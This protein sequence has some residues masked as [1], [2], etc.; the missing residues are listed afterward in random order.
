MFSS[1]ICGTMPQSAPRRKSEP[2]RPAGNH[3]ERSARCRF[4]SKTSRMHTT[5]T[6]DDEFGHFLP[7]N[8]GNTAR[9]ASRPEKPDNNATAVVDDEFGHFLPATSGT[10]RE[11][12]HDQQKPG[13]RKHCHNQRR[14]RPLP[15]S[16]RPDSTRCIKTSDTSR[17]QATAVVDDERGH[18]RKRGTT[19]GSESTKPRRKV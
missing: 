14:A 12:H 13:K 8:V 19:S 1:M 6:V 2:R 17:K 3:Q 10:Q 5:A 7:A 11:V 4:T 15:A 9:G 16:K 18:M